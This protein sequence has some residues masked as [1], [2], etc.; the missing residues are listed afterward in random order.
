MKAGMKNRTLDNETV[1]DSIWLSNHTEHYPCLVIPM[2][3][4]LRVYLP[5]NHSNYH[6]I[7]W[8]VRRGLIQQAPPRAFE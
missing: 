1:A 6:S 4:I 5:R 2:H 7:G 8:Y 3:S